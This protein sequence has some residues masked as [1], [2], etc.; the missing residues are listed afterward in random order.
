MATIVILVIAVFI[1]FQITKKRKPSQFQRSVSNSSK[2]PT[3][4]HVREVDEELGYY[5][6]KGIKSFK[7]K[8][9]YY[10]D[11]VE[12][13]EF[14]GIARTER[15]QHDKYAVGIFDSSGNHLGYIPKGNK[16]M[17]ETINEIYQGE[18]F[19]WGRITQDEFTKKWHGYVNIPV[20]FSQRE[21]DK[22][23]VFFS[24]DYL[25]NKIRVN[26][27]NLNSSMFKTLME[28]MDHQYKFVKEFK[29]FENDFFCSLPTSIIPS[30][31]KLLE[32]E[33]DFE[34]LSKFEVFKHLYKELSPKYLNVALRRIQKA[35]DKIQVITSDDPT[36][37]R[38]LDKQYTDEELEIKQM[39]KDIDNKRR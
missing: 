14:Q 15:N 17:N 31:M 30:G 27:S 29:K 6:R 9:M 2:R 26:K 25:I 33:G 16:R 5:V 12:A 7:V 4:S 32:S 18:Q 8:G 23:K 37:K 13:G 20:G 35:K 1:I 3:N 28:L 24:N 11:R 39:L 21:I 34:Y 19:C 22:M 38:I 36:T 10:R